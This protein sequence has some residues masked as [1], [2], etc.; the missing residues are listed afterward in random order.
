MLTILICNIGNIKLVFG[1]I[2]KIDKI[3][4]IDN[5]DDITKKSSDFTLPKNRC[6]NTSK[7]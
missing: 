2:D 7:K 6:F 3:D 1:N 4:N 5:I